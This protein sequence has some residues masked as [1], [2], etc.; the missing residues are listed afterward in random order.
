MRP[1]RSS[2]RS[3][4]AVIELVVCLPLLVLITLATIATCATNYV[5]QSL[6]MTAFEGARIGRLPGNAAL[7]VEAQSQL[8]QTDHRVAD[9]S[10]T[11]QPADPALL[12]EGNYFRVN[13]TTPCAP[14]SL[15][16]GWFHAG[17]TFTE[18]SPERSPTPEQIPMI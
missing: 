9:G 8:I 6:M 10:I 16:S 2:I 15:I 4:V 12:S 13:V 5:K 3:G 7:N 18:P 14:N 11:M 1:F 17:R